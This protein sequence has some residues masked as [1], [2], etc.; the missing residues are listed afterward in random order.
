M[1]SIFGV[2]F[3]MMII[4]VSEESKTPIQFTIL[5]DNKLIESS[6]V[7]ETTD[8]IL[9]QVEIESPRVNRDTIPFVKT[10][11]LTNEVITYI[12]VKVKFGDTLTK[13][14]HENYS[15]IPKILSINNLESVDKIYAGSTLK[16][17]L[18][19]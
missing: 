7:N 2:V 13:I 17:P 18:A 14:A 16:I 5:E 3:I 8:N 12:D 19:R 6:S 11:T 9:T 1:G 4:L 10:L 15:S